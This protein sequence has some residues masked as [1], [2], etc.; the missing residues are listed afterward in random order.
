MAL[1][2]HKPVPLLM[3]TK[4]HRTLNGTHVDVVTQMFRAYKH[5]YRYSIISKLLDHGQL[6]AG[7]LASYLGQ[8]EPYVIEQL[9]ILLRSGLVVSESSERGMLFTAN[10]SVLLR[11]KKSV[12]NLV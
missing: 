7:Q 8:G 9:G 4:K 11:L 1:F 10:E 3:N 12:E 6:S 2:Y 5:P